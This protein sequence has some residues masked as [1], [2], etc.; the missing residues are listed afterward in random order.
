M[1]TIKAVADTASTAPMP[2]IATPEMMKMPSA[3]PSELTT[4]RR[5]P[6]VTEF[7]T[8]SSTAG[9]GVKHT[10]NDTLQNTSQ[11]ANNMI[12]S[13]KIFGRPE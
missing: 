9:P 11:F 2:A 12:E 13:S 8:A 5:M 6:T 10:T 3:L 4:V 7:D 1:S